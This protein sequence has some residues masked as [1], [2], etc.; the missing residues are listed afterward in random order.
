M[1][2]F[3]SYYNGTLNHPEY[4]LPIEIMQKQDVLALKANNVGAIMH[5]IKREPKF[6]CFFAEH[7][8]KGR[9]YEVE[10]MMRKQPST[11]YI[12][13]YYVIKGRWLEAEP[14]IMTDSQ[15]AYLYAC[16]I[17]K[18]RWKEAEDFI[19]HSWLYFSKEFNK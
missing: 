14:V 1:L 10:P 16:N 7:I 4:A 12:Y 19:E 3:Y 11:V 5:I 17:I 9:W 2:N 6:V 13:A 18:G 8:I 15:W